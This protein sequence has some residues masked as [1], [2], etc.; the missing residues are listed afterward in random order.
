MI[1]SVWSFLKQVA[2]WE[3]NYKSIKYMKTF[4]H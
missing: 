1:I 3:N 4:Y 2:D